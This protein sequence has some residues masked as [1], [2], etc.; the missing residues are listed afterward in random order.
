MPKETAAH[1]KATRNDSSYVEKKLTILKG[2]MDKAERYLEEHPWEEIKDDARRERE[3]KFQKDLTDS[4][5]SWT[6][7]YIKMC[8]IMD[9]YNQLEAA[10]E[11]GK[12]RAGMEVSG[13]QRFVK[14]AAIEKGL[15]K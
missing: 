7:S 4:L 5:M 10:K 13:I 14:E 3:F 8:G 11:K 6:E 15:K 1:R 9:V 2:Q 12:L